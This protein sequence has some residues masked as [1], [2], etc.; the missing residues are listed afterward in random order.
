MKIQVIL[1]RKKAKSQRLNY[2]LLSIIIASSL[3]FNS[4]KKE[5]ENNSSTDENIDYSIE[6]NWASLPSSIDKSVDLFYAYPTI[7]WDAEPANMDINDEQNRQ[8]VYNKMNS[9]I[10]LYSPYA[11]IYTPFYRQMYRD[12]F[13]D[14][15]MEEAIS[16]L[17]TA[18]EDIAAAFKYYMDN[19][20]NGRPFILMGHSQGAGILVD[21]LRKEFDNESYSNKMIL[22]ITTGVSIMPQD[23]IDYPWINIAQSATDIGV[24]ITYNTIDYQHYE[25]SSFQTGALCVNPV[26][27]TTDT[28]YTPKSVNLGAVWT[29]N[30]G[31]ITDEIDEFTDCYIRVDGALAVTIPNPD[32]YYDAERQPYGGYHDYDQIFFYR[33]LQHN[34]EERIA[35]YFNEK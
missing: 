5:E 11:N 16:L 1:A 28:T 12:G 19:L 30:D 9:Q 15:S 14:L 26:L 2:A 4:C 33:N 17:N 22:A 21:L 20:N 18:Y 23:T 3:S 24:V 6:S 32:D 34:L 13:N 25:S 35:I 29:D 10:G 8:D 31:N 7:Y 27:W